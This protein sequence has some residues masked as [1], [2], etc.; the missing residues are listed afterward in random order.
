MEKLQFNTSTESNF[1]KYILPYLQNFQFSNLNEF[2]MTYSKIQWLLKFLKFVMHF[3]DFKHVGYN[4][5]S[6]LWPPWRMI[7]NQNKFRI[8]QF[9]NIKFFFVFIPLLFCKF[10][11][12]SFISA[13]TPP[14]WSM[15]FLI[16]MK[17]EGL[18]LAKSPQGVRHEQSFKVVYLYIHAQMGQM[19]Y[20]NCILLT[21]QDIKYFLFTT[22]LHSI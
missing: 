8:K 22:T 11:F 10:Y 6:D 15:H 7:P 17:M 14:R 16:P 1:L 13:F 20:R 9:L 19:L 4:F 2:F 21:I 12:K 5:F 18:H 3:K